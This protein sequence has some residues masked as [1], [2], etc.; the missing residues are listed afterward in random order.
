MNILALDTSSDLCS[1]SLLIDGEVRVRAELAPRRHTELILPM[2]GQLL[3]E[4]G[5]GINALD[6][7]AFGRGPGSFTGVR[8]AAG[9][10]QGI[11]FGADIPVAP[12]STLAALAHGCWREQGQERVLAAFDARM[13]EVY[14]AACIVRGEGVVENLGEEVVSA[15][16]QIP[17]PPGEGWHGAGS[18]WSVYES[19]L[20]GR[21][22]G[23]V[24]GIS[25]DRQCSAWDI[26][27][28]GQGLIAAGQGVEAA[29]ALPVYLRNEVAWKVNKPTP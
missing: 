17:L 4:A 15:P 29:Q 18:G 3:A 22:G 25:P 14:W 11:A 7:L 10:A 24:D 16:G 19:E 27:L 20:C 28:I 6:G 26:V 21:L 2:I 8:I 12:V 9:V 13:G 5:I 23:A 1:A